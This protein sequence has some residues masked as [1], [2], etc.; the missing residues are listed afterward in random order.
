L[1]KS[2]KTSHNSI[3]VI[4]RSVRR[5]KLGWT[6][7]Y[8]YIIEVNSISLASIFFVRFSINA[9]PIWVIINQRAESVKKRVWYLLQNRIMIGFFFPSEFLNFWTGKQLVCRSTTHRW[10]QHVLIWGNITLFDVK[11]N[12]DRHTFRTIKIG[13][14]TTLAFY[15]KK[16]MFVKREFIFCEIL[17]LHLGHPTLRIILFLCSWQ[18]FDKTTPHNCENTC[19]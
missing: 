6:N 4:H 16:V 10:Q 5:W 14:K 7:I 8:M 11:L 15:A 3:V 1:K 13:S 2:R 18:W 19:L 12:R 9:N 17:I